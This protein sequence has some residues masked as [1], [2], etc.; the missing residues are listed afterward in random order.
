MLSNTR[1]SEELNESRDKLIKKFDQC[2]KHI[3]SKIQIL[4]SKCNTHFQT[5]SFPELKRHLYSKVIPISFVYS[6]ANN[7]I[8]ILESFTIFRFEAKRSSS[9]TEAQLLKKT[10]K[11]K[12]HN[13]KRTIFDKEIKNKNDFVMKSNSKLRSREGFSFFHHNKKIFY[14]FIFLARLISRPI[15]LKNHKT[16]SLQ[17]Y[18][19]LF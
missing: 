19:I 11:I 6:D 17:F 9:T 13:S 16:E 14:Q 8:P 15:N 2:E 5:Y 18:C 12:L 10:F 7:Y 3:S 4:L 1:V